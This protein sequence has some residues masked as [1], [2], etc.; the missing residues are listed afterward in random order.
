MKYFLSARTVIFWSIPWA[1]RLIWEAEIETPPELSE[2]SWM[3]RLEG[4]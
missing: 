4:Y 3:S 1:I 2:F